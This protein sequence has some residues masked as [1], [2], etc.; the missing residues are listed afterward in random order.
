MPTINIFYHHNNDHTHLTKLVGG[1]KATAAKQLSYADINLA[2]D[3][4]SV[5]IIKVDAVGM[6]ADVELEM[7]AHAY[8]VRVARQDEICL[9]IRE[10]IGAHLEAKEVRVWLLLTQLGHSWEL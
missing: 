10:Y 5:R 6:L 9:M 8:D 4:I 2:P 3:E 1:L 7:T